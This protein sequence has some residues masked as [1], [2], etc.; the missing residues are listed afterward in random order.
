MTDRHTGYIVFLDENIRSDDSQSVIN[1]IMCIKHV[2]DVQPL[3]ADPAHY[4]ARH[5]AKLDIL[6]SLRAWM[7]EQLK[8]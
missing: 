1:A 5:D 6:E 2:R 3:V 7:R 8:P 4:A